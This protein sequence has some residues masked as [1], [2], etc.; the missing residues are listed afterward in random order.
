MALP[1]LALAL[2]L[3]LAP[4]LG[5]DPDPGP[6]AARGNAN[7]NASLYVRAAAAR[8]ADM[9]DAR[10]LAAARIT[11]AGAAMRSAAWHRL[12]ASA[13]PQTLAVGDVVRVSL[14][15]LPFVRRLVKSQLVGDP[16]PLFSTSL[17]RVQRATLD[18]A[19]SRVLYNIECT[20]C[21]GGEDPLPAVVNDS[22][23]QLPARLRRVERRYLLRVA[24][25]TRGTMGRSQPD[26]LPAVW[27]RPVVFDAA[28]VGAGAIGVGA[29]A[30]ANADA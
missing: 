30:D 28:G 11:A 25:G 4:S 20:S 15:V 27:A 2:A 24:P 23:A 18:A 13:L 7:A 12:D 16:L 5:P 17:F 26:V 1:A 8:A 21:D 22:F 14:L 29:G 9:N 19:K 3:A 6:G 10:R